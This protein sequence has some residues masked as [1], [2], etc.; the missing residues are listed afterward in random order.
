MRLLSPSPAKNS[1]PYNAQVVGLVKN[2]QGY[3]KQAAD[4]NQGQQ[5]QALQQLERTVQ[6][7]PTN[8]QAAFNLAAAYLQMQD[9][10]R[11]DRILDRVL[12][13]PHVESN[14]VWQSQPLSLP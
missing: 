9:T 3:K 4:M 5:A 14:A 10:N 2:L 8:Y 11:G 7:N 12:N 13:D 6:A 1:D